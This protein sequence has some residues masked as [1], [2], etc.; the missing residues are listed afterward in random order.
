M[1]LSSF[2]AA[3]LLCAVFCGDG[4]GAELE[5]EAAGVAEVKLAADEL[6]PS[7]DADCL[8]GFH[9]PISLCSGRLCFS[10]R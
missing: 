10:P 6:A 5:L 2:A 1:K 3:D 9:Q 8:F 7:V 4:P